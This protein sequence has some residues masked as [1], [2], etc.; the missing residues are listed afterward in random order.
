MARSFA[1]P[2]TGKADVRNQSARVPG[3]RVQA[4]AVHS[5]E[6]HPRPGNGDIDAIQSWFDN[7]AS[8]ASSHYVIDDAGRSRQLVP[9]DRKAW[10]IGAANSWTVNYELIGFASFS[11]KQWNWRQ[12]KKLAQHLAYSSRQHGVPLRRGKVGGSGTCVC[13]RSGV[14]THFDVTKAGF[15]SHTDP[16]S[17]FPMVR[18]LAMAKYYKRRGWKP[19]RPTR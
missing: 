15:G 2:R 8:Q 10:T 4:L 14:I 1:N 3:S 16:G 17:G 5:T 9:E 12:L 7:P 11:A 18:V 19:G 6:S 13:T